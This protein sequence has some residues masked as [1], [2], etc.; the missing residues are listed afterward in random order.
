MYDE[1]LS[2][3]TSTAPEI[4][5]FLALQGMRLDTA[6]CSQ[7]FGLY[8]TEECSEPV[9]KG[10]IW[11]S[12]EPHIRP[13]VWT[14]KIPK[15]EAYSVSEAMELL[16]VEV[17]PRRD[18][19]RKHLDELKKLKVQAGFGAFVTIHED[20]PVYELNAEVLRQLA[21]FGIRFTLDIWDWTTQSDE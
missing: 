3:T 1:N 19:I 16:L 12:G 11:P 21:Y 17:W 8:P 6:R 20:R 5:A 4:S 15:I 18:A 9:E 2:M 10:K 13:P 14:F 7:E